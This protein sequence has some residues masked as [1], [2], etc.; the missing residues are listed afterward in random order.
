MFLRAV[1]S[2]ADQ[3]YGVSGEQ[4]KHAQDIMNGKALRSSIGSGDSFA[5][6]VRFAYM[7]KLIV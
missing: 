3:I 7:Q 1:L 4:E 2:H 6:A 5:N